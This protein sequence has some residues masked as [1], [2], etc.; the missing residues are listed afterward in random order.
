MLQLLIPLL[1]CLAQFGLAQDPLK[2]LQA[3]PFSISYNYTIPSKFNI[4]TPT[5][6]SQEDVELHGVFG[7]KDF[8]D[9]SFLVYSFRTHK[10]SF[11]V[12]ENQAQLHRSRIDLYQID[13]PI[14]YI[15]NDTNWLQ[16]LRVAPGVYSDLKE[17][18]GRDF[19]V[20]TS[21]LATY[22]ND[23]HLQWIIGLSHNRQFGE[24]ITF[25]L[26]GFKFRP[27]DSLLIG[28]ILPRVYI[29]YAIDRSHLT[30]FTISPAG[31]K[32][33]IL[34]EQN[35]TTDQSVN[36]SYRS[37]RAG[38]SYEYMLPNLLSI[39]ME[40]GQIFGR[41]LDAFNFSDINRSFKIDDSKFA[42]LSIQKRF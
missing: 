1:L 15:R 17:I 24:E 4:A 12:K 31:N 29:L 30:Q 22:K 16:V 10:Q 34:R 35:E 20:A 26:F 11:E 41:E 13:F 9:K 14:T 19:D 36:I 23:R 3:A 8:S 2:I 27:N 7:K 25:P 40:I 38:V 33:N 32:W 37:F 39:K 42:S 18:D 5:D 28:A 21:Y 6:I